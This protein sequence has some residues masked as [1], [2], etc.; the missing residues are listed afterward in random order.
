M[1]AQDFDDLGAAA[2]VRMCH[3]LAGPTGALANGLELLEGGGDDELAREVRGLLRQSAA[4]MAARLDFF[5]AV[6]GLPTGRAV[7]GGMAEAVARGYLARLGD[8]NRVYELGAFPDELASPEH[9]R[10]ALTLVMI[11]ADGLPFGG[12]IA[13]EARAGLPQLHATGR[14]AQLSDAA[15]AAIEA[16]AADPHAVAGAL[17]SVRAAALGCGVRVWQEGESFGV[18]LDL[19][20]D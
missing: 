5:R 11:G 20:P 15:R 3:D 1:D 12:R 14:R 10:L 6:F 16:R 2:A 19:L 8:A 7:R 18:S 13:V 9:W 4:T 17:L